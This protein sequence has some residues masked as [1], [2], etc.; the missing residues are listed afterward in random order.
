MPL[1]NP[2]PF[3][4]PRSDLRE[5]IVIAAAL[6]SWVTG[7]TVV[8]MVADACDGVVRQVDTWFDLGVPVVLAVCL[9]VSMCEQRRQKDFARKEAGRYMAEVRAL[10]SS[11]SLQQAG[12][13]DVAAAGALANL[14]RHE[15]SRAHIV[16]HGAVRAPRLSS[17]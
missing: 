16:E 12:A 13:V 1:V 3:A 14:G 9:F 6:L 5:C 15:A 10:S 4:A 8:I 11:S 7:F 17:A 2:P